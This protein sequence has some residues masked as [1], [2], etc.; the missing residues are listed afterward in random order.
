MSTRVT[1]GEGCKVTG[2]GSAHLSLA[3]LASHLVSRLTCRRLC[4]FSETALLILLIKMALATGCQ[5]L[6]L[7]LTDLSSH[8]PELQLTAGLP[9]FQSSLLVEE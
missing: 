3:C 7:E 1:H 4:L 9:T 2:A 5:W 6:H 8:G